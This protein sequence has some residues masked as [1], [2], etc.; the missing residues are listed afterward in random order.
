MT[1]WWREVS[2]KDIHLTQ[3]WDWGPT[4]GELPWL[5]YMSINTHTLWVG[6]H[7]GVQQS[8][9]LCLW[10]EHYLKLVW[11]AGLVCWLASMRDNPIFLHVVQYRITCL[12]ACLPFRIK[13]F[14]NCCK[15]VNIN[16][17]Q[18]YT[19]EDYWTENNPSHWTLGV[20]CW[21]PRR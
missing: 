20:N 14:P 10:K 18:S 16:Y 7:R 21:L 17:V 12:T 4:P 15:I 11:L 19:A 3:C 5:T 2:S 8:W 6:S 9:F 13:F 1:P